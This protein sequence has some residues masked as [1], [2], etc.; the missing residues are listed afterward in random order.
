M[1]RRAR[2]WGR[3]RSGFSRDPDHLER[4]LVVGFA[5][6]AAVERLDLEAGDVAET[7]L[8]CAGHPPQRDHALVPHEIDPVVGWDVVDLLPRF[9]PRLALSLDGHGDE[10]AEREHVPGE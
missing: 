6:E 10:R 7:F 5:V 2:R 3:R 9:T 8:L 1:G 4:R